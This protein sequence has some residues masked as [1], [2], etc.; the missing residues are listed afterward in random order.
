MGAEIL[1]EL[2]RLLVGLQALSS[3][4]R[5]LSEQTERDPASLLFGRSPVPPGPG[6]A[7]SARPT[8]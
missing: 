7:P 5:H 1:P 2:Q 6:E 3:S 4:L 8:P